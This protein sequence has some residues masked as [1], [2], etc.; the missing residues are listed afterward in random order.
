MK[1][2]IT[3]GNGFVGVNIINE[4][5]TNTD[6]EI[7]CYINKNSNN[8]VPTCFPSNLKFEEQSKLIH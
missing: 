6:W 7:V 2:L 8:F 5:I 4:I 3:G 1:V